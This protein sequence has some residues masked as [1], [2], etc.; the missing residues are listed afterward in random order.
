LIFDL[1]R[2]LDSSSTRRH[3]GIGLALY[4]AKKHAE[5]LGGDLKVQSELGKGSTFTLSCPSTEQRES[6][7]T[8]AALISNR[9]R[10]LV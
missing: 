10:G 9:S 1:F 8:K 4:L 6:K 7:A 5:L 2:Q 3:G